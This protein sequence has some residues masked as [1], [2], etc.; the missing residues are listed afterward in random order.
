MALKRKTVSLPP[1]PPNSDVMING[2][3]TSDEVIV[4]IDVYGAKLSIEGSSFAHV[5]YAAR[6]LGKII[7]VNDE[8]NS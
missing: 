5:K 6:C 7:E 3:M 8:R 4:R 2:G 1:S